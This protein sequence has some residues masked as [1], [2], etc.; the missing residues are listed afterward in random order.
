[1]KSRRPS[2]F[3]LIELLVVIAIIAILIALLVPAVQKVRE[4]SARTQCQNN[5]KQIGLA[6]QNYYSARKA[7]PPAWIA[8]GS[9]PGWGWGAVIL[10]YLEQETVL[11]AINLDNNTTFST[12]NPAVAN[13]QTQKPMAVFRCN[14]DANG[15]PLNPFRLN[16]ATS[17][18]RATNGIN[19]AYGTVN[20]PGYDYGGC[21]F[22]N[23]KV[24]IEQVTD[25]TS[26][27]YMIGECKLFVKDA[28]DLFN[29]EN[30]L[31]CIWAGM[32]GTRTVNGTL[33]IFISDVVWYPDP[34]SAK[35][36]GPAIQAFGSY[37]PP[38]GAF[39]IFADG[40]VRFVQEGANP[41]VVMWMAG[42]N[43]N[44]IPPSDAFVQ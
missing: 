41:S 39:F 24:K 3:T 12:V 22:Q 19:T 37:H 26:N 32:T 13:A 34:V 44:N 16:F 43:D 6:V 23:S 25:G 11:G 9:S 21:M 27:T 8:P 38:G 20:Q 42:R 7:F 1:M 18:F 14:S 40:T 28:A 36:N 5:M 29:P 10:P 31:A 4:A 15:P 17:N 30:K 2:A 35:I 33:Y